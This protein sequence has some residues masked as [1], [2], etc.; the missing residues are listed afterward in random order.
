MASID[1][2]KGVP[3]AALV[4]SFLVGLRFDLAVAS[5]VMAPLV[6]I[7]LLPFI[8]I[9]RSAVARR[10]NLFL[11]NIVTAALFF[12]HVCDI[13]FFKYF[14]SR[15][16]G[17]ALLWE[18]TPDVALEMIWQMFPVVWYLLI[19]A[20]FV[21][22]FLYSSVRLARRLATPVR[23]SPI[24]INAVC[25]ILLLAGCLL[26]ARGRLEMKSPLRWGAAYFSEYDYANQLALNPAYTFLRDAFIDAGSREQTLN[27]LESIHDPD[28]RA[29]TMEALGIHDTMSDNLNKILRHYAFD[30]PMTNPPNV[31]IIIMETF[32]ATAVGALD[33]RYPYDLTP[34]FDSL[35]KSG[36]L[37]ANI[38]AA[39]SHTYT[40]LFSTLYGYPPGFGKQIMK[41]AAT[42][43]R[44]WGLPQILR[45]N[46]YETSFFTTHDPHFDNMQ[47]F[48]M[49]NGVERVYSIHDYGA[50]KKLGAMGVPDGVMYDYAIE[51]LRQDRSQPFFATLL[52][53]SHHGPW[54]IPE[55]PFEKIPD[56]EPS[57]KQLNA[58]KYSDW[59]M[60]QFVHNLDRDPAFQNTLVIVTA[61]NG[62]LHNAKADLDLTQ[63]HI[64]LLLYW[65][66][67]ADQKPQ[68]VSRLGSQVDI[69]ATL[70]GSLRLDYDDYSFGGNL[71]DTAPPAPPMA[72]FS[73]WRRIGLVQDGYYAIVRLDGPVSLYSLSDPATN[74]SATMPE[75]AL[76][77][78]RKALAIYQTA[79]HNLPLPLQ[80]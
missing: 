9:N 63:F 46:G 37:F 25:A 18:E 1:M 33:D 66:E 62:L 19:W 43:S 59:A 32:G 72:L 38:Y 65:I 55:A 24:L 61:D 71:L 26:G 77:M 80:N 12:A 57:H 34:Q 21:A 14:N 41:Q 64:P 8:D 52:T 50:D 27:M 35:A 2:A 36:T 73:E 60:G 10:I 22:A 23:Q 13:E 56:S 17:S 79:H 28:A 3:V 74:L 49:A 20:S 58:L 5:Y 54:M 69:L 29:M 16:D 51:T 48:L 78:K 47:G 7:G 45:Q 67:K 15:L 53:G 39:G 31:V 40:G 76:R 6:L 44:V 75:L 4:Q 30:T 42:H 70:M 11:L 68:R